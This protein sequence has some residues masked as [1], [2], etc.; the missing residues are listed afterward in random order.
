M[1]RRSAATEVDC[2]HDRAELASFLGRHPL[3]HLYAL[4]DL[5]P[6]WWG[7]TTWYGLRDGGQ[8]REVCLVYLGVGAPTLLALQT[9][10]SMEQLLRA[11]VPALPR[12]LEA[13]LSPSLDRILAPGWT[14]E[15][16][17]RHLR[18]GLTV[19]GRLDAVDTGQAVR[20]GP[21]HADEL[22][23]LY[24]VSHPGN[25]F[26]RTMLAAGVYRGI[27]RSGQLVSAAGI[28][29][30]SPS[31]RVAAL[32]NIATHPDHRGQG[33]ATVATAALCRDL[34]DTVD[35][36]GLNVAEDNAAA[37]ACYR[38]LGFTV[39]LPYDEVWAGPRRG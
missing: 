10:D 6:R 12:E 7:R 24:A 14:V 11:I 18:M 25:W 17:G 33:L 15:H 27:R 5:D 35:T 13:H 39:I 8:L 31:H 23:A 3:V 2:L 26:D 20:L 36:I 1:T 29:A 22:E 32:G 21:E 28:H 34:L 37:R 19:P 30:W 4:A 16:H 9:S 38:K